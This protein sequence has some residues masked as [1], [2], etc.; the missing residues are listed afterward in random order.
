MIATQFK[1]QMYYRVSKEIVTDSE[2]FVD[3]GEEYCDELG[4]ERG[5]RDTYKGKEDHKTLA[6]PCPHYSTA[7]SSKDFLLR[8]L[9][10]ESILAC[11]NFF[12]R[13]TQWL[14]L[15]T[16]LSKSI[17]GLVPYLQAIRS[18]FLIQRIL[19]ISKGMLNLGIGC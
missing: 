8:H 2:I 15:V 11:L 17:Y 12:E 16:I 3:Y 14:L 13:L 10:P 18:T 1:G 9:D 19:K 6:V 7:F 4:I 5:T